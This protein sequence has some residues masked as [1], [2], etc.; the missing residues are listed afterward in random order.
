MKQNLLK[1][2]RLL[3]TLLIVLTACGK[4]LAQN[5]PVRGI[6]LDNNNQPLPGVT[7]TIKGTTKGTVTGIEGRF[8]MSVDK[9]QTLVFRSIGFLPQELVVNETY[10]SI[11]MQA[12]TKELTEVIVTAL[13]VKK[14]FQK[15]GYS[16]TQINGDDLTVGR[17]PN[18]L[19]SL[20]GKVAGL[21]IGAS[22]EMFGAP[23]VVLRGSEDILYVI[24]GEPVES[25]TYDFNPDDIDTY[26]VLKGPNAAA[27]YG[28]RGINGA[29]IITTKKGTNDKK[30]WQVD[31]NTTTEFEKGFLALP[32]DQYQYGRG[33][34][35]TYAYGNQLYD[36]SQ[37]LPEWGPRYDGVFE[38]TQFDSP[39][40]T[41]TGVRTPTPWLARGINN[42]NDFVQTGLVNTNSLSLAASGSNYDIRVSYGHTYQKGDFPNTELNI[43]NFKMNSGY[44]ITPKLRVDAT[45]NLNEQYSPN[46]PD[47]TYGP[48]SYIYEFFVYGSSDYPINELKN[49]YQGPQGI[50]NLVQYAQEYGRENN[51]WFQAQKWLRGRNNQAINGSLALTY[52][53]DQDLSVK[54]RTALNTYNDQNTEEVPSSANLNQ[55]LPWYS[56]GWYGDY[57]QD[58]RNLLENNTDI[59]LNYNHKFGNFNISGLAGANERSFRYLSDWETT[60]GLS[61]P[62]VYNLTNTSTELDYNFNS[63][64]QVN[65]AYYSVDLGYKNYININT[66]GRVDNIST[67][68][69]GANTFFYPSVSVSSVVNDYVKLPEFISFLKVRGSFADVKGALTA[70]TIGTAYNALQ[71]TA[72]GNG[73]NSMPVSGLL[74]YGSEYYTPYNGPTYTNQSS[75]SATTY[76]NGTPSVQLSNSISDPKIK[77]YDVTSYEAGFDAK[78]LGNRLGLNATYFTTTNGPNI[79]LLPVAP[80]TANTLQVLN[81][82]TTK[83]NGFEIEVMGSPLRSKDGL[84]WD[85]NANYS[86]YT[87]TLQSVGNGASGIYQNGHYYVVGERLDDIYGTKFVRDGQ[88]DII[89]SGGAP[90]QAPSAQNNANYG[91]LGHADPDFSFG[92][93]NR[94][95]Y[96]GFTLSFQFDGRIG[97]KIYDY[98]Y[99]HAMNGGTAVESAEGAYGVARLAEWNSTD[100]GTKAATPAFVGPGVVITGGTPVFGPGGVITNLGQLTF[101]PNTQKVTTQ[102]YI[103][104]GLGSNF[105]E[106]YMISR[107]Y[108]KL[109]EASLGYSL[110]DKMLRGTF[111]KKVTFSV[112]G[113]NLLY[114]AARKDID[115]DQYASGYDAS[116]RNL[117]GNDGS[118]NLTSPTARRY[119]FNLHLTF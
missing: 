71:S 64:M 37:R 108:A 4:M 82:L 116:S 28:S 76:Y 8:T 95:S 11:T 86:T 48:N 50:P 73:W 90:L 18:P 72:S 9:G 45:L 62:N 80:S 34:N 114:F 109:R 70:P 101:A 52:K 29:I 36:N 68:P 53:I 35:F 14:E 31:Y 13:G 49:I 92:I 38:T 119:G 39:Y 113:R 20:A 27:L 91:L 106:Y 115:L 1:F 40:N 104:S 88:G 74:G 43:D 89:N 110:P 17:D 94:F 15:L 75:S 51:P 21:S 66:T 79:I 81:G 107:S 25:N 2:S 46:V 44:D 102:A 33:T 30:G 65:S 26:T 6:V 19:N 24:D 112:V 58:D 57:R 78:F 22:N 83:K 60:K 67:L 61:L 84:N 47:A 10:L 117:V 87:E 41:V 100:E 5:L 16:Q 23:T 99:Y 111:I 59:N 54:L 56:F 77:P 85:I 12:D 32:K 105:D 42:F 63:K 69:S 98:T 118:T 55:Y 3:L 96:K 93:T 103:S 7:V 97:G